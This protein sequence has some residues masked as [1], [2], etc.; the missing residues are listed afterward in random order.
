MTKP[1][2][3][4]VSAW[5][6]LAVT[7]AS[8]V[9]A[10][11]VPA[12]PTPAPATTLSAPSKPTAATAP[13]AA[14]ASPAAV[15]AGPS[16]FQLNLLYTGELWNNAQGGIRQGTT[17]MYN[18]D[19]QLSVDTDLAFGWTGGRFVLEGFYQSHNSVS[20][21]YVNGADWQS[22]ID[23]GGVAMFR[24]YQVY[25]D[26][27]IGS[28]DIRFGIYDLETEFSVTKPMQLFLGKS[29]TWNTALD[30]AGTAPQSGVIGPG[31]FP[32]TP[33]ALR[34]R[35]TINNHWSIQAV[36]ADGAADNP[37]NPAQNAVLFSSQYGAL[38]IAEVDYTPVPFTKLMAGIWGLTSKLPTNN[39][40][41]ADGS[42]REIYGEEGLY[43]G[44]TTRLY[45][46]QGRRG[47]D[48]FFTVGYSSPESTNVNQSFNTGLVYTGLFAARPFDKVG[49]SVAENANPNSYRQAQIALGDAVT[50][51]ETNFEVTYRAKINSWLT[52]QPDI[53]YIIHPG[54]DPTVKNDLLIGLHF[55]IG[56][57]FDL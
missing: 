16:P 19:A 29:L 15:D 55:E 50:R 28:T 36:I 6:L 48:G 17:Y 12:P 10:Q 44:G 51:Y 57:F 21:S 32:Y 45:A 46:G 24:L 34:I 26:Q 18:A 5:V 33:L 31:N 14:P 47:L 2:L 43:F 7:A 20:S 49:I 25:Y 37:N 3:L 53:Q 27:T 1:E 23:S 42:P 40:F 4:L 35:E 13:A 54:Y 30:E 39:Q 41:N 38:G 56:H 9:A 8:P 52:V 11:V 22:S